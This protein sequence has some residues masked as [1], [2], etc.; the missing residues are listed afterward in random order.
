[1]HGCDKK[2]KR[3]KRIAISLAV[4]FAVIGILIW[5]SNRYVNPVLITLASSK[6]ESQTYRAINNAVATVINGNVVYTDL[7]N[8]VKDQTGDIKMLQ[9][10]SIRVNSLARTAATM[11]QQNIER[12]G[13]QGIEVPIGTLSGVPLLSGKGFPL[14][15]QVIPVGSVECSFLSEFRAAGINQTLHKIYIVVSASVDVI[16]PGSSQKVETKA[17]ILVTECIL[18]GKIPDTYLN[19]NQ[20]D[21]AMDLIPVS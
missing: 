8:V 7:V 16:F 17:Q 12:I 15:I 10:N 20:L 4:L 9:T 2:R 6:V 1:M 11:S 3:R 13:E 21:E 14:K 5:F 18:I 19:T